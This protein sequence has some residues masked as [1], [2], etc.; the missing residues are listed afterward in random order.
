MSITQVHQ[1]GSR[2][3]C[4]RA[5]LTANAKLAP[6]A[7]ARAGAPTVI[8]GV[9]ESDA[10]AVA[11]QLIDARLQGSGYAVVNLGACTPLEEFAEAYQAHP[12]AIAIAIGSL[13]GHALS[14]LRNLAAIRARHGIACPVVV[15]G[16]LALS[17]A[18]AEQVR[19]ALRGNG[20]DRVLSSVD[21]LMSFL[22]SLPR[23]AT[24]AA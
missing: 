16:K 24:L 1:A 15:G 3:E 12:N 4:P 2:A 5:E 9:A 23:V 11:N 14:D 10:H 18:G 13:N 19:E 20:V 22:A 6:N 17:A 21:E 7:M 8:L